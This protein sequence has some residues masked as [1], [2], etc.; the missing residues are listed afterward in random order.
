MDHEDH[1]L[2]SEN[3]RFTYMELQKITNNFNHIIGKGGFGSVFLGY[4]ENGTQVAVKT[5]SQSSSQGTKEFLAE[6]FRIQSMFKLIIFKILQLIFVGFNFLSWREVISTVW[7]RREPELELVKAKL[8]TRVHHKNLVS[9]VGYCKDGNYLALVYEVE[10]CDIENSCKIEKKKI[11]IPILA[12]VIVV[13]LGALLVLVF[14]VYRS[15]NR[16]FTYMELQKITNNFNHIIGKGGFGSVFLG[17]LENGTQ[18]AV[19]TRS[20]SSS[21]GTK[22]FLAEYFRIQSM[23]KLIIFKILQLIFV[24]FNFLSWRE[25]ISTVW[26]R[27]EPEL[28]LVK[29][30]LLTRVHHKNL[31]SL[32]GYCKDGNYLA[33]VYEYM[34][35]GSLH[36]HLRVKKK[37][38]LSHVGDLS[39]ITD[40]LWGA[41]LII[42]LLLFGYY[43]TYQL[44]EKSDVYSFGVVLLELITGQPPLLPAPGE[45][46]IVQR[47]EPKVAQGNIDDVVDA[48]LQGEYDVNSVWKTLDIALMCTAQSSVQRVTMADVV[49]QL[50]ES[51][52]LQIAWNQHHHTETVDISLNDVFEIVDVGKLSV[53]GG[54][55]AR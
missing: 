18:V 43:Q 40:N 15:E 36:D 35:Q 41:E 50:R 47:V 5:R 26:A 17:Y 6:Y 9:L 24:G 33:L 13:L 4:L 28:E 48:R 22:E 54:P 7:A 42:V 16:R 8:L 14:T 20:Q 31:V 11:V 44:H 2:Q 34:S 45:S 37:L 27:R 55:S 51:L 38:A 23:F 1:P 52:A 39:G 30:K 10:M 49:M 21:Q 25:V 53:V 29:A 32:V 3:R 46:H 19:K 12:I